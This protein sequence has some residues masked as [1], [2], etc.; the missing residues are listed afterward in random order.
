MD[1]A[2]ARGGRGVGDRRAR[3]KRGGRAV[4]SS[5]G[6][7]AALKPGD[8]PYVANAMRQVLNEE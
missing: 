1:D 2:G 3:K 6:R 8:V 7:M 4:R 5:G